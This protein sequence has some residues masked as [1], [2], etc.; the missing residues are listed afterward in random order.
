[1]RILIAEDNADNRDMISRRLKKR[2]YEI[3]LA[4]DGAEAV[5]DATALQPD[6]ILM[7]ISMP[8]MSGLEATAAI[9]KIDTIKHIPI[10]ALTAHA[11]HSDREACKAAGCNEFATKPLDFVALI[12]LIEKYRGVKVAA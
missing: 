10:I 12:D 3:A 7:D 9:R 11:L 6:L 8:V 2:G 4:H 1:M 5:R